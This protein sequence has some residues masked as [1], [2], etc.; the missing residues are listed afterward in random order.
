MIPSATLPYLFMV[1]PLLIPLCAIP[2]LVY[3]DVIEGIGRPE[4]PKGFMWKAA[5]I[6]IRLLGPVPVIGGI[7]FLF[8]FG[9][10]FWAYTLLL[11]IGEADLEYAVNREVLESW[12]QDNQCQVSNPGAGIRNQ[13][14][15]CGDDNWCTP[16][17]WGWKC[18][19]RSYSW[20][21]Q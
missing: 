1:A 3:R 5:V 7:S 13:V 2:V 17:P 6:G 20:E 11:R 19:H 14:F 8:C 12:L 15:K 18:E 16:T 4:L 10:L 21:D 9:A